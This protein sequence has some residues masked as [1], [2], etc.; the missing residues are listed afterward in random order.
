MSN[1]QQFQLELGELD[2][3][4][5]NEQKIQE[6]LLVE[7]DNATQSFKQLKDTQSKLIATEK[8]ASLGTLVAG[9]AHEVNTPLGVGVTMS[10]TLAGNMKVFIKEVKTGV[11]NRT[12]L[13]RFEEESLKSFELLENSLQHAAQL[14]HSFKQV[15]VDQTSSKRREFNLLETV[16]EITQT[17][18]HKNQTY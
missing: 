3:L 12:K 1:L 4:R 5:D 6:E 18:H 14:I 9:V 15:A 2:G 7:R 11:L 17:L 10:S 8:M 16:N 13:E